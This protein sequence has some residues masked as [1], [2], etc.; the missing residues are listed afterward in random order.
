MAL[1]W[2]EALR[3]YNA[4]MPSWCIPR[5]GTT[6]Y[7]TITKLRK[8]EKTETPKEVIDKL[9]RKTQGKPKKEKRIVRIDLDKVVPKMT[10]KKDIHDEL[11]EMRSK[12]FKLKQ[13]IGKVEQDIN[14]AEDEGKDTSAIKTKLKQLMEEQKTLAK[15][16]K[17]K[18]EHEKTDKVPGEV[19]VGVYKYNTAEPKE[20]LD[21]FDGTSLIPA[22]KEYQKFITEENAKRERPVRE[23]EIDVKKD[24]EG[25]KVAIFSHP[26]H[27][28]KGKYLNYGR[29][30][31]IEPEFRKLTLEEGGL[32][33]LQSKGAEGKEL[34]I[35]KENE[36]LIDMSAD[37]R[38]KEKKRL[39]KL[40]QMDKFESKEEVNKVNRRINDIA[41]VNRSQSKKK[42]VKSM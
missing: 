34:D 16:I 2:I 35:K 4:G 17:D 1:S 38:K 22:I 26:L 40:L 31:V 29:G 32:F 37:E 11:D 10:D 39:E 25:K 36:D 24:K 14:D 27:K 18:I 33:G 7:D 21:L 6:A 15:S 13:K 8:G 9:E 23:I 3:V 42:D 28:E 19:K 12:M 41:A 30:W 5:K 20:I